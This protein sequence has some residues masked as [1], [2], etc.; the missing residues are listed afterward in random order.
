MTFSL[1]FAGV[2]VNITPS[3]PYN[4]S[5]LSSVRHCNGRIEADVSNF[6]GTIALSEDDITLN[7]EHTED[8]D[9]SEIPEEEPTVT[10]DAELESQPR[11]YTFDAE[12]T[13]KLSVEGNGS[14]D[15]VHNKTRIPLHPVTANGGVFVIPLPQLPEQ[16]TNSTISVGID[17]D[18]D[19]ENNDEKENVDESTSVH[20]P[21]AKRTRF[22]LSNLEPQEDTV[23]D[24]SF[25]KA[26]ESEDI[27]ICELRA[28]LKAKPELASYQDQFGDFPAHIFANNDSVIYTQSDL[29]IEDFVFELYS[30]FPGGEYDTIYAYLTLP[31]MNT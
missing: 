14:R 3:S 31:S 29:D 18:D 5:F 25:H 11:S 19:I 15:D 20:N 16:A 27:N 8:D 12:P 17:S 4:S 2:R 6:S 28:M 7:L 21:N 24:L 22:D 26:C 1:V 30:A 13:M 9:H 23:V 10:V